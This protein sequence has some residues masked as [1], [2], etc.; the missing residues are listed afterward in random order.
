MGTAY[1][2][3]RLRRK[4]KEA[5][6]RLLQMHYSCRVGHIGGNLSC[7]DI[8]MSL[9]HSVLREKDLF[10]LSKGHAAGALYITL[11]TAGRIPEYE[12]D[13]FHKDETRLGGHPT[14]SHF[15]DILFST[16]SLGHGLSLAAGL[17]IGKVIKKE[18]GTVYCLLSE[19]DLNEGST[20]EAIL[21]AVQQRLDN[22]TII[23]DANGLQGFGTV[24]EVSGLMNLQEKLSSFG[25]K[26]VEADGHDVTQL[27]PAISTKAERPVCIIAHTVKGKGVSFMEN[28]ME[29]HYLPLN[30]ELYRQAKE[31]VERL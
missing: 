19:G 16:G 18:E 29:W 15:P 21:F 2:Y 10:V 9:Y 3:D 30:E 13:T 20:W 11:W 25:L 7:L 22:L 8:L 23:I 4:I 24:S 12:L 1:S 14:S 31:E 28:Q 17:A 6:L 5:K 26:I 27:L